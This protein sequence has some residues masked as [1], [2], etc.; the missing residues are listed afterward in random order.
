LDD[1]QPGIQQLHGAA[2]AGEYVAYLASYKNV[3]KSPA[4]L[5]EAGIS[6]KMVD[7]WEDIS[8][9]PTY[10]P[11]EVVTFERLLLVPDDSFAL[12]APHLQ[13]TAIQYAAMYSRRLVLY[14]H[15]YVLYLDVFDRRHKTTFCHYY[16]VPWA[17]ELTAEGFTRAVNAPAQYNKAT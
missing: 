11:G 8:L 6:L 10:T 15:G 1:R 7:R 16:R 3:G 5:L 9:H 13:M 17:N 12:S 14:A 4:R 2:Q